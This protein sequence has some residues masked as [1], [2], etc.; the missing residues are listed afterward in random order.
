MCF[1]DLVYA[2][3]K[4]Q[5]IESILQN[6]F[7]DTILCSCVVCHYCVVKDELDRRGEKQ[8]QEEKSKS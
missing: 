4:A 8:C 3:I 7:W 1:G 5:E 2:F 6:F